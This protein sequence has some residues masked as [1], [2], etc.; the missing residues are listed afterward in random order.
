MKQKTLKNRLSL[1]GKGLHT[2]MNITATLQPAPENKR[3]KIKKGKTFYLIPNKS[4]SLENT[5][6]TPAQV[7][8]ISSPP[9][10]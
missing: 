4:H 6:K 5:G 3:Y 10:F 9:S 8:W 7:L 1:R 2:G